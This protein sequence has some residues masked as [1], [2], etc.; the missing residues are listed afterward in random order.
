MRTVTTPSDEFYARVLL[1]SK[2]SESQQH[3]MFRYA[4]GPA[5]KITQLQRFQR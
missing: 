4:K 5:S 1:V 2:R 3:S